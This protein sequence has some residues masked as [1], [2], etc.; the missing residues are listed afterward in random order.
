MASRLDHCT[1]V[2]NECD[3][4]AGKYPYEFGGG[5]PS[6]TVTWEK[7]NSAGAVVAAKGPDCSGWASHQLYHGGVLGTPT[8]APTQG[9]LDTVGFETWGAQGRGQYLTLW[10]IDVNSLVVSKLPKKVRASLD[11]LDPELAQ[12]H[13]FLWLNIP[14]KPHHWSAANQTG[15]TAGWFDQWGSWDPSTAGYEPRHPLWAASIT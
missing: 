2:Y 9:A 8:D 13:C 15:T 6:P 10:V 11:E 12:H 3:R 4:L 14:G 5:H 1:W 7:V